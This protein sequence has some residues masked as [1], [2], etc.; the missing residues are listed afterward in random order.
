MTSQVVKWDYSANSWAL[1]IFNILVLIISNVT[2][3]GSQ[4]S[5]V[6]EKRKDEKEFSFLTF[7]FLELSSFLSVPLSLS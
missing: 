5:E 6:N 2:A 3:N 1:K 7:T 4:V